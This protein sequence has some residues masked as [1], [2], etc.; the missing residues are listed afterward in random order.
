MAAHGF[1][2]EGEEVFSVKGNGS[3]DLGGWG[4]EA[5]EGQGGCGFAGARLADQTEGL[6]GVDVERDVED[7]WVVV[8]RY[9]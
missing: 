3:S 6:A 1:F 9:G 8:E 2:G 5:E 7:G 4:K